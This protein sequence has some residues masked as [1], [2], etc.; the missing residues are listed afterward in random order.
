MKCKGEEF[1]VNPQ[2]C[3]VHLVN[4]KFTYFPSTLANQ[5]LPKNQK[6]QWD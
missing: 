1:L 3:R 5:G 6:A 2:L 4:H